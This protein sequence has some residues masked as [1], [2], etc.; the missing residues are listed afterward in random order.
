MT[1]RSFPWL[2]VAALA[3][4]L[5][6]AGLVLWT[7]NLATLQGWISI[8]GA[9]I[10]ACVVWVIKGLTEWWSGSNDPALVSRL[11]RVAADLTTAV[12]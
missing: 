9:G 12:Q 8:T 5:G 3:T 7:S 6:A 4:I 11:D 2:R 10:A 1:R